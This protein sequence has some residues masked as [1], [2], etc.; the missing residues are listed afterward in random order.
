VEATVTE[1]VS[2]GEHAEGASAAEPVID[3]MVIS[4]PDDTI[5]L[6]Q[7]FRLAALLST[8]MPDGRRFV[9]S[10]PAEP[11][12]GAMAPMSLRDV[13]YPVC[14]VNR[15]TARPG[16]ARPGERVTVEVDGFER[17]GPVSLWLGDAPQPVARTEYWE[18]PCQIPWVG[19]FTLP[20]DLGQVGTA[21]EDGTDGS[22]ATQDGLYMLQV[23]FEGTGM[24]AE[25]P[26][27]IGDPDLP[28]WTRMAVAGLDAPALAER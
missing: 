15:D 13:E 7:D 5:D 28:A 4:L 1:R 11:V 17:D 10:I 16:V 25:C 18:M 21:G 6:A 8:R 23:V 3:S 19:E 22:R 27:I 20:E 2:E 24:T 26:V 9:D 12:T 14:A